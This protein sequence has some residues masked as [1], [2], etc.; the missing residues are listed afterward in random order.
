MCAK[1]GAPRSS[2]IWVENCKSFEAYGVVSLQLW[3]LVHVRFGLKTR[4]FCR[5][6]KLRRS[7][8]NQ[9]QRVWAKSGPPGVIAFVWEIVRVLKL[10]EL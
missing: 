2:S 3:Y 7:G 5:F 4:A 10:M 6:G 9:V 1:S 8:R